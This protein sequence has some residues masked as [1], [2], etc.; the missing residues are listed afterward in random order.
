MVELRLGLALFAQNPFSR[1]PGDLF[2]ELEAGMAASR[3]AKDVVEFFESSLLRF[4]EE[5]E[6]QAEGAVRLTV[7]VCT[8]LGNDNSRLS[9]LVFNLHN[10]Q[11][12]CVKH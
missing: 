4:W 7:S 8:I 2:L 3:Y 6:D 12:S 11:T 1:P 9:H 10:V 5:E